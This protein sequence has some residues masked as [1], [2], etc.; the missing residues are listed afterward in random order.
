[1]P[2]QEVDGDGVHQLP[3][4]LRVVLEEVGGRVNG[5]SSQTT[6]SQLNGHRRIR[7]VADFLDYAA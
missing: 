4:A 7:A 5:G 3:Q 1:M 2:A 6:V